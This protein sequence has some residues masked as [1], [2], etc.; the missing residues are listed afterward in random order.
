MTE[1]ELTESWNRRDG[2]YIG[3]WPAGA[4]LDTTIARMMH[5]THKR[6]KRP[7]TEDETRAL[8]IQRATLN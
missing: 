3:A 1:S 4:E 7:L 5:D 8:L 2:E 6:I